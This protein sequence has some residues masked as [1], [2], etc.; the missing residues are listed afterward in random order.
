MGY[1]RSM[2]R[3]L[4]GGGGGD[5]TVV[6][7]FCSEE[8]VK[9]SFRSVEEDRRLRRV[10]VRRWFESPRLSTA[11]I[12]SDER[13]PSATPS[14]SSD[15]LACYRRPV[16]L[17]STLSSGSGSSRD[18]N[19][20]LPPSITSSS[21]DP[22]INLNL[23]PE[24]GAA[25]LQGSS[26]QPNRKG[27][28]F[29]HNKNNNNKDWK[30]S[31]TSSRRQPA[32]PFIRASMAPNPQLT[33]LDRVVMEIIETERMYVRDLRMIVEDY[34]AHIIDQS[35]QSDLSIRPELVCAL[36]GN[37]EDIYEFNSEL[38]QDLD[39]CDND[40][41]AIARCF[42]MKSEYFDIYTQYCTNYPN[43]VAALTECMRNKSLAKFF[44]DRQ[45]SLKRSLP[46]GSY[47]LKPVQRILKYHLLLQE[48]EKHFDPEEDGYEVVEEALYTMTGVAWYINDMKRKHEHAVRLQEVQSLLLNW[49]GPDLTTYGEL[50][51]EGNFKVH[52]AKNERTLFLFD[53]VLLIT[54]R[55]GE[56]Y[57]YKTHISCS[58]LTLNENAKDSLSFSVMHYKNPKQPH[59][60]QAKTVEEKKLWAHHIKRIIVENHQAIIPQK[61]KEAILEMDSIYPSKY[62]YSPERLKKATSCHSDEFP[63]DARQ[64]RR[65]SEPI[66]QTLKSNKALLECSDDRRSLR[67]AVSS[68]MLGDSV[69]EEE[70][71][72]GSRKDSLERLLCSVEEEEVGQLDDALLEDEQVDDFASSVL[73]AISCWH[74]TVQAFLSAAGTDAEGGGVS[75]DNSNKENGQLPEEEEPGGTEPTPKQPAVEKLP[76]EKMSEPISEPEHFTDPTPSNISNSCQKS[77][78][79]KHEVDPEP[80]EEP[81]SATPDLDLK[82]LSS[83]ESSEDED[84]EKEIAEKEGEATSILPSSVLDKASAIAQHFTNSIKRGSVAQ[85]DARSLGCP[86]PRLPS[87]SGSSLSLSAEAD[88][89]PPRLCSFVADPAET[90]GGTDLTMLSPRDDSIFDSDRSIRRRR[91]STLSKQDQ[92]LIGKIKSYY[93]NAENQDATFS[94]RRR[95]SLTYIPS[96]L[97][98]SS[99]SRFNS[100]STSSTSTVDPTSA[101]SH[102]ALPQNTQDLMGCSGS[103]DSLKSEQRSTDPED[104]EGSQRSRSQS[105]QDNLSDDE[106]FKPSS[107]MIKIWQ[108]MERDITKSQSEDEGQDR[109]KEAPVTSRISGLSFPT[110]NSSQESRASDLSTIKEES[111]SPMPLKP[112]ASEVNRTGSVRD[113]LKMFGEEAAVLRAPVPRVTQLKVE[114]EKERPSSASDQVVEV[115]KM[116]SKV[117]HLARQYSQRIKTSSPVVRQRSQGLL[118]GKK[119]LA[120]VVEEREG[121]GKPSLTLPLVSHKQATSLP[122]SPVD[123]VR[124]LTLGFTS[125]SRGVS[126]GR[127]HSRSPLS[128]PPPLEGFNWPDVQEL[129]SKYSANSCSQKSAVSRSQSIPE[130][131]D[132]SLRRHSSCPSGRFL[133][134]EASSRVP[135]Q[136]PHRNWDA[137]WEERSKRLLRA[138]SLDPRL[139]ESQMSDLQKLQDQ[140]ANDSYYIA[141]EAPLTNDPEHKIIVMEKFPEPEETA[142]DK[143]DESYV[144]IR[145]PTSREKISIMAVIDRCRAYQESDEYQQREELKAKTEQNKST[146]VS[147]DQDVSQKMRST[148]GPKVEG[149][150]S[151]VKNLRERFQSLS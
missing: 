146:A 85:D 60:V 3:S 58:T 19:L 143:K 28:S 69:T 95:E 42:V 38:L 27:Q 7:C 6:R 93:E 52:R 25:D 71:E 119:S 8:Q 14:D 97:V 151:I 134:D 147:A 83:G 142:R 92:L 53:R 80:T 26:P 64:G 13:A 128:P 149:Q 111:T 45:S 79:L 103:L 74:V 81:S 11:S 16:S 121:S 133:A 91:D 44:R 131:F 105:V 148:S 32:S 98:R 137:S 17:I 18:D 106:E 22:D 9:I 102:S 70:A 59:T 82:T 78:D 48:I 47:L 24:E 150:Q 86:S 139:S 61:A 117:L 87:R 75:S 29:I 54:K 124:S 96:G 90:F 115:D 108:A 76:Q 65:Q 127:P 141:A 20:A 100:T 68:S 43:S 31:H 84:N 33:Y 63:R 12:S 55:R 135:S 46:L 130:Q 51:L 57:V 94:L 107:K 56:H 50:V 77:D 15:L 132:S 125:S 120:S 10:F 140:V 36:F 112:K 116:A 35:D 30:A 126:P 21:S 89:R 88:D 144:Q 40:P 129:R 109:T 113:T 1:Q 2:W 123:H 138:N 5:V 41:V 145:S 34:L 67:A 110:K 4:A 73:A 122:L 23:S 49:K 118:F 62:R 66:K 39:Q 37:I 101:E 104:S 99:V 114:A 136:R 72:L